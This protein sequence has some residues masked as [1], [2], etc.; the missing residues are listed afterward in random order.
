MKEIVAAANKMRT[1]RSSKASLILSHK[2]VSSS[3]SNVF[4]PYFSSLALASSEDSP[5]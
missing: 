1:R 5:V 2:D 4:S 3:F